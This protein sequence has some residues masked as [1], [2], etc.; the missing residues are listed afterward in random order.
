ML[1]YAIHLF[2]LQTG[3]DT[4]SWTPFLQFG[5][6]VVMLAL[7]LGFLIRVTPTWK[8]IK[9]RDLDQRVE[10]NAVKREQAVA[11]G[12]LADVLQSIAVEQRKATEEAVLMQR[13]N[14]SSADELSHNVKQLSRRMDEI[15]HRLESLSPQKEQ[16]EKAHP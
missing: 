3:T 15:D 12:R 4:S 8:E 6:T 1:L 14:A 13:M 16:A 11:L 7:I 10:E 2:I 5:P 9:L